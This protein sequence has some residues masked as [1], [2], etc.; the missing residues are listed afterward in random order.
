MKEKKQKGKP[1]V[2]ILMGS[3]SDLP[4]MN[5][6]A[7]ALKH[8][9]VPFE[10]AILSAH[11]TP[12]ETAEFASTARSR[13]LRVLIA[14]AGA[15]AHLAGSIAAHTELPVIGVPVASGALHGQDSLLSTVQM[16]KGIPVATVA[17]GGAWN[18]GLLAVQILA[19]GGTEGDRDLLDAFREYKM[20]LAREALAK[21]RRL[22]LSASHQTEKTGRISRKPSRSR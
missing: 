14:G 16:P 10:L 1:L 11:R 20:G 21:N 8:F 17:I 5:E 19:A 15:A 9:G 22:N 18:A 2:G 4:T 6:A 13:G 12:C 3:D 7:Q